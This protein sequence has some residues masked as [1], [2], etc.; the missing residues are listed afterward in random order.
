MSLS[1]QSTEKD[2]GLN[3]RSPNA[4]SLEEEEPATSLGVTGEVEGK[5]RK[6]DSTVEAKT[7]VFQEESSQL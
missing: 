6:E 2:L 7:E 4:Q 1:K 3:P 5:T